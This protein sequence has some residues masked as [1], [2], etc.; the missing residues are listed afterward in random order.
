MQG[1]YT[2]KDLAGILGVKPITIERWAFKGK[3]VGIKP[4]GNHMGWR[5]A[6][7]EVQRF[8]REGKAPARTVA[9]VR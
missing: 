9:D 2:S 1:F 8:L 7:E 3:I 5:F 6:P 4:G